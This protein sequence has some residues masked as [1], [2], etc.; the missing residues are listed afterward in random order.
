MPL[1]GLS[2]F[3]AWEIIVAPFEQAIGVV[4]PFPSCP[5][6]YPYSLLTAALLIAMA[7]RARSTTRRRPH[8]PAAVACYAGCAVLVPLLDLAS[9]AVAAPWPAVGA[10]LALGAIVPKGVATA[11]LFLAW[12]AQLAG[13][14]ARVAWM[15]YAG[16]FALAVVVFLAAD[17]LGTPGLTIG[18]LGLPVA[19]LA[20]LLAARKLPREEALSEG[21]VVW[22]FPWRPVILMVAFSFAYRLALGFGGEELQV[23]SELG[24]L[25]VA[26]VVL[27]CL[28]LAF[29]RFDTSLLFKVCPALVVAGL[30]LCIVEGSVGGGFGGSGS[31]TGA[32]AGT[33]G[34]LAGIGGLGGGLSDLGIRGFLVSAGYSGFTLYVY[35]TLNTVCYRF[36][37]PSDW[38]FGMTRAACLLVGILSSLLGG[39][40]DT[41][42]AQLGEGSLV[43][44]CVVVVCLVLLSMLLMTDRTPLTTWGIRAVRVGDSEVGAAEQ[45]FDTIGYLEDRVYRCALVAR[46]FGLTH[47]EEEVLSLLVQGSGLQQIEEELSIAHGTLRVHVQHIYAKMGVHSYEEAREVARTWVP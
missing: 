26:G 6:F 3:L 14:R 35:L 1:L 21:P 34:G 4:E 5:R 12:N 30:L 38:L 43:A 8:A 15:A 29:D 17:L 33:L 27:V 11:G 47:R 31:A 39:W 7:C 22:K 20:A 18:A 32:S 40:L 9:V 45:P 37:A 23:A 28:V 10:A 19:S 41:G 24:R 16:S 42:A 36:G 2:L 25:V 13:H 44:I 46:H